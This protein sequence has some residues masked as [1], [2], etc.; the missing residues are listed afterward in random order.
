MSL[1]NLTHWDTGQSICLL[2]IHAHSHSGV[3]QRDT[4]YTTL[5]SNSN[6]QCPHHM[7]SCLLTLEM[8]TVIIKFCG[9]G[10]HVHKLTSDCYQYSTHTTFVLVYCNW[11]TT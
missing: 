3:L 1:C 5:R 7:V 4:M 11:H 2:A 8:L 6:E 10:G 9:R